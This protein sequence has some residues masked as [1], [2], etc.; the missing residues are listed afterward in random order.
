MEAALDEFSQRSFDEAS[1]NRIIQSAGLNKGSFYY[2]FADKLDLYMCM[3]EMIVERKMAAFER[4]SGQ[5]EFP[6]D[7]FDQVRVLAATGLAFA[8]SEPRYHALGR[9]LL[10]ESGK[11][12]RAVD[13][14][15]PEAARDVLQPLVEAARAKGQFRRDLPASVVQGIVELLI[16]HLDELMAPEASDEEITELVDHLLE[17]LKHGLAAPSRS[18]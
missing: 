11:V 3:A 14:R 17:F 1:L 15:F 13:E 2:R 9:R 10:A 6:E 7:F 4:T 8:R 5:Q 16:G 18:V 12:R